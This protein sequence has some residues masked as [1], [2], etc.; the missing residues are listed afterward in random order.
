MSFNFSD[1]FLFAVGW[2]VAKVAIH[3]AVGFISELLYRLWPWVQNVYGRAGSEETP[4]A[5][6]KLQ[7]L[8]RIEPDYKGS[9]PLKKRYADDYQD[10]K[11]TWLFMR[12]LNIILRRL[13]NGTEGWV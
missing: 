6:F 7:R 13:H 12:K 1:G 2:F 4:V 5:V 11:I 10:A 9:S 8:K 3:F